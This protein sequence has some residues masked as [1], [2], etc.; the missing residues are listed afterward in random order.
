MRGSCVSVDEANPAPAQARAPR[1]IRLERHG[2]EYRT[3]FVRLADDLH[4]TGPI[5]WNDTDGGYWFVSGNQE[6]FD[7]ARRA[8][9]L[10][11]D[12]DPHGERKGYT[13]IT[14]PSMHRESAK[15]ISG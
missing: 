7:T 14:I 9:L 2:E 8:D 1:V 12:N 6:L 13:G 4:A 15:S 10:S 5:A 11:N 3:D